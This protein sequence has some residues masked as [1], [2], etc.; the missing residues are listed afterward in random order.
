[1]NNPI[2]LFILFGVIPIC[3][4]ILF[5]F[6]KNRNEEETSDE[7]IPSDE[8]T[9]SDENDI[10]EIEAVVSAKIVRKNRGGVW[11]LL[12]FIFTIICW[13]ILVLFVKQEP[14]IATA[15]YV[16]SIKNPINLIGIAT[17]LSFFGLCFHDSSCMLLAA[18]ALVYAFI[19]DWSVFFVL[20]PAVL[21]MVSNVRMKKN[22]GIKVKTD[23]F[24]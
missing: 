8:A 21:L 18:I 10:P 1:M 9:P 23:S 5:S 6:R 14:N 22:V 2:M 17:L 16:H 13:L 7:T 11:G 12:G 20:I 24:H 19:M 4:I 3:V 15:I